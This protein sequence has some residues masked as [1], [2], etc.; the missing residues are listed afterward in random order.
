MSN[1][2]D[3]FAF[4]IHREYIDE[5]KSVAQK[6]AEIWKEHGATQY[7]EFVGDELHVEGTKSFAESM[8]VNDG[9]TVIFGWAIFPSK[10]V[11]D[12]ANQ[13]VRSDPR[14][15]QLVAPLMNPERPIFDPRRMAYGGFKSL[16]KA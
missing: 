10:E 15:G 13:K 11:R 2:I 3:G 9:E 8:N 16:V 5:Y 6:V 1:Y 4:P 14:M 7:L 12:S